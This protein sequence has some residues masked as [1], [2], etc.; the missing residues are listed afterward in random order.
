MLNK[1]DLP[2]EFES[3]FTRRQPLVLAQVFLVFS[4]RSA[5]FS[6]RRRI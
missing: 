6:T 1:L 2:S 5:V 4:I 3:K